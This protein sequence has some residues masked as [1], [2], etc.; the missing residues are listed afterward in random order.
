M[1]M[2]TTR[3]D[4]IR[5][6]TSAA[7]YAGGAAIVGGGIALAGEAKGATP[8]DREIERHWQERARAYREFEADP[9]VLDDDDAATPYWTRID[10]AENAILASTSTTPRANEIR[11]WVAWSHAPSSSAAA[12]DVLVAQGDYAELK[13][14]QRRFDWHEKLIFAAI[15]NL[16]GEA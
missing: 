12:G 5:L 6:A 10:A 16:R 1:G 11:L 9:H 15:G 3:R 13:K 14:A 4:M 8:M 2:T 7:A